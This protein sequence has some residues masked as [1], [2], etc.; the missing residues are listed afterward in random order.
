MEVKALTDE[1]KRQI[2]ILRKDGFSYDKIAGLL[3]LSE[4]TVKSFCRRNGLTGTTGYVQKY[5]PTKHFC[6]QCGLPVKQNPGRKLKKFCSDE[7]RRR[8]WN[9]HLDQVDR[10]AIYKFECAFCHKVFS[11]YG[12]A[13]RKYCSHKCYID[14]RYG[15]V[16]YEWIG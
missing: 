15:G 16:K 12:N 5:D 13:G 9:S 3:S 1:Q 6:P 7:C 14:D 4:N 11:A 8:F 2:R 10:K